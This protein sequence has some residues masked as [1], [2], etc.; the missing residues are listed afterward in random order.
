MNISVVGLGRL[1][2]PMAAV[3]ARAGLRTIGVDT[4]AAK[5]AAMREHQ[6]PVRETGL[7]EV[8]TEGFN[9]GTL[10]A[11]ENTE[12]AVKETDVTFVVV[13]TPSD[14]TGG[15]S[16]VAVLD[17]CRGIGRAI[18]R[19]TAHH[20]VVITS[21]VM[22]GSCDGP[23]RGALEEE[24][25]KIC[26]LGFSL[27]YN[28]EF[29]ALGSVI[30]DFTA[31]D[32]ILIG[33]QEHQEGVVLDAIYKAVCKEPPRTRRMSWVNAEVA[34]IA[35]NAFVTAKISFANTLGLIAER[36]PGCD[37][38]AITGAL[39]ADTRIGSRYLR[40]RLSFGGPCFPRDSRAMAVLCRDLKVPAYISD[41]TDLMNSE[42]NNNLISKVVSL[43]ESKDVVGILGLTYK[44]N[45]DVVECS[46]GMALA[47]AL[48]GDAV[49]AYDPA[50]MENA[51][52]ALGNNIYFAKSFHR[53]V[54]EADFLVITTPWEEF[55]ALD[56]EL[57]GAT[58][59]PRLIL[60]CW[61]ILDPGKFSMPVMVMG[62]GA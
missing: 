39:A 51:A 45:T 23:I 8:M 33:E 35:L 25:G 19:K 14:K 13:P 50:G 62:R 40:G 9:R 55:K 37:V 17:A 59:L 32:F 27:L 30:R 1:G 22:P 4:D 48:R 12:E 18:R 6:P 5:I 60:D 3:F 24:S 52:K 43:R 58:K 42:T 15:F 31:P 53:C 44:A 29:I 2:A 38:D 10:S 11:T 34:K 49:I 41:A 16:L 7:L 28:P 54:H 20:M 36:L 47:R 26:G 61:R 57:V 21:T 46:A 56:K